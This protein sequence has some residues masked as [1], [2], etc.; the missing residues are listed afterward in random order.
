MN[1]KQLTERVRDNWNKYHTP[2]CTS[3]N[4]VKKNAIFINVANSL[5]HEIEK[6]KVCYELRQTGNVFI[7]ESV[8]NQFNLRRDIVD[9][10]SG[11]IFEIETDKKR[12]ERFKGQENVIVVKL[13]EK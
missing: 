7:T 1:N 6:L 11:K 12:A 10:S 5:K 9:L 8:D 2:G 3:I 4:K 13:W